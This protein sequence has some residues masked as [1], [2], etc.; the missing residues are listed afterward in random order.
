MGHQI[1]EVRMEDL[2]VPEE[3][4]NAPGQENPCWTAQEPWGALVSS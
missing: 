3:D 1:S 2:Q 4:Q